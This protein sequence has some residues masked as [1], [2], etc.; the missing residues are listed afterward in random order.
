M[1]FSVMLIFD[2]IHSIRFELWVFIAANIVG[3][4]GVSVFLC[5]FLFSAGVL[6]SGTVNLPALFVCSSVLFLSYFLLLLV[7]TC[8]SAVSSLSDIKK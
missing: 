7:A 5:R 1:S 6:F 2:I 4:F 3:V 8:H